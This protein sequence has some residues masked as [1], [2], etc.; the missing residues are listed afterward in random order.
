MILVSNLNEPPRPR[1][2]RPRYEGNLTPEM[3]VEAAMAIVREHGLD[4]L[5]MRR[6]A[7]ELRVAPMSVYRHID[8]RRSLLLLMLDTVADAVV[9]PPLSADPR[10]EVTAVMTAIHGVLREDPWAIGLLVTDKLAS[11]GIL[12]AVDRIFTALTNSGLPPRKVAGAYRLIWHY[13]VGELLDTHHVPA[14]GFSRTMVRSADPEHYPGLM[15]VVAELADEPTVDHFAD[16]LHIVLDG[17]MKKS[18]DSPATGRGAR[19]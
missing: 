13:T 6:L 10:E 4:T 5:T 19:N 12:P 3:I 17:V 9:L 1:R 11:P 2:R 15:S 8:D 18:D 7:T 14:D 16:N